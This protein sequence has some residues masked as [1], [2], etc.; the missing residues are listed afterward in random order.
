MGYNITRYMRSL[1]TALAGIFMTVACTG[2]F[3][4]LNTHPSDLDPDMMSSTERVGTLLPA[5]TYL[6]C[7]QQ[8]NQSQMIDQIIFGQLGGYY[9]CTNNWENNNIATTNPSDKYCQAPFNDILPSFY[10]NYFKI[11]EETGGEGSIYL[12]ANVLRAGVMIRVADTYGPIPYSKVDGG[13]FEVPYDDLEDLYPAMIDDLSDAIASIESLGGTASSDLSKYDI[14]YKGNFGKWLKFANSLKFR[15]AVRMSA[16][17]EEFSKTAMHEAMAS[18][19]I[20]DN[21]D[22]A[23]LPTGDNPVFKATDDWHDMAVNATITSYM[24]AYQD[25]RL[26]FYFTEST[27]PDKK[28]HGHPLGRT[29]GK[30]SDGQYSIPNLNASSPLP[31]FYA[32]ESYFLMAEAALKGW[33]DGGETAAREYYEEGIRKSME[34][35]GAPVGAYLETASPG[36]YSYFDPVTNVSSLRMTPPAVSW[37]EVSDADGHLCQILTQKYIANFMIGLES[38]SDFRR[39]GYPVL[40]KTVSDRGGVGDRQIRRLPY[41]QTEYATNNANVTDAVQRNFGSDSMTA[42]LIWAKRY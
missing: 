15:M 39:T 11:K 38:W 33:I 34:Q 2:N 7:P 13:A 26:G 36:E 24:N 5:L 40:F 29:D 8:E 19:M 14:M 9:S 27:Q 32:A 20:L 42:D 22:N 4:A 37:D 18:G 31:V 17:N 21:A 25:P 23:F 28:Y 35:W 30:F 41:P 6:L 3:E 16:V 10:S 12:I 1:C